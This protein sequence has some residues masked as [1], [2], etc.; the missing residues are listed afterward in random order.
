[1]NAPDARHLESRL[2]LLEAEILRWNQQINL[3]SRVDTRR[4]V[5]H[6]VRQCRAG[7]A[8]VDAALADDPVLAE[9]TYVDIGSGAGLPGLVWSA[10]RDQ[11]QQG[12]GQ[13]MVEPRH[14]RAWFLQRVAREMALEDLQVRSGR[15]GEAG[16]RL[17]EVAA[18]SLLI[19]LKALRL[20]DQQILGGLPDD[21]AG[22]GWSRV[23]VVRFLEPGEQDRE[24]L[25]AE[26][27]DFHAPG[28]SPWRRAGAQVLGVGDP[29]LLLTSY[30][31]TDR[32]SRA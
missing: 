5:G 4:L 10:I 26:F 6:L 22:P 11:R 8:L 12:G 23:V 29:A 18:P 21:P 19:S 9:A 3:V 32:G 7:W 28:D 25:E 13:I 14:K 24:R 17:D 31:R 2:Q 30:H 20:R 1:M 16:G 15:W 27:V